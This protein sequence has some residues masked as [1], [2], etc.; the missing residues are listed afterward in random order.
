MLPFPCSY[1]SPKLEARPLPSKGHYGLFALEVVP[2]GEL[3]T[4]WGGVVIH[5][6][7][8]DELPDAIRH[9]TVQ[10]EEALYLTTEAHKAGPADYVNHSCE[11]NAGMRG[12]S[13]LVALRDIAPGEEIC[14][15]Y[16]MSDGS[17]YDEFTCACG[18][19]ACRGRV[20]GQDWRKPELWLKYDGYFSTYL[21]R[22]I[23]QLKQSTLLSV[24]HR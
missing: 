15:D 17:D 24:N 5:A 8:L 16:A 19:A 1:H 10:I 2:A 7:Q 22:R 6:S 3:L 13:M 11:P 21:Q 20:T 12:Y 4:A 23:D 9:L 14:Y 18:A